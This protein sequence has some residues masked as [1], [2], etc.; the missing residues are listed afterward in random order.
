MDDHVL[1]ASGLRPTMIET[2]DRGAELD[3][4]IAFLRRNLESLARDRRRV[5]YVFLLLLLAIPGGIK[6]GFIGVVLVIVATLVIVVSAF[7]LIQGHRSEY[8]DKL[9]QLEQERKRLR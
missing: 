8:H 3:E 9:Q 6:F 1:P 7:Y 2:N 4:Q 5:P